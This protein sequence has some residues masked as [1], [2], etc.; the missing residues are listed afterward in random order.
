MHAAGKRV[1]AAVGVLHMTGPRSLVKLL[2]QRGF[3]V[4]RVVFAR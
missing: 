3:V 2:E 4:E 1:F